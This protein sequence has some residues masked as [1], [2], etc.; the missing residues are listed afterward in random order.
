MVC[1]FSDWKNY[2][3]DF[4]PFGIA[5]GSATEIITAGYMER[6]R[7]GTKPV[8]EREAPDALPEQ[9]FD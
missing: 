8:Q 6:N 4:F 1:S 9:V 3:H 2:Y 7:E 5:I